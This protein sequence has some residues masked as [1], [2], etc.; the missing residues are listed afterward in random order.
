MLPDSATHDLDFSHGLGRLR[1]TGE[2]PSD[3]RRRMSYPVSVLCLA[4][5]ERR[6]RV[7]A[8]VEVT[9][10]RICSKGWS[11]LSGIG[12]PQSATCATLACM[13]IRSER[14][15]AFQ[16]NPLDSRSFSP[17]SPSTVTRLDLSASRSAQRPKPAVSL[18][19][20]PTTARMTGGQ[21]ALPR[22]L[23]RSR[24]DP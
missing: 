10:R 18:R 12:T 2:A 15:A 5:V 23:M 24:R 9:R 17:V 16:A 19:I 6:V 20:D 14:P 8:R 1:Y 13:I 4:D 21:T 3:A 11:R 22:S 7:G